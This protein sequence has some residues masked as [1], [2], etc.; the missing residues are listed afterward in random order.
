MKAWCSWY[1]GYSYLSA[2]V[3]R[4]VISL[5]MIMNFVSDDYI[6]ASVTDTRMLLVMVTVAVRT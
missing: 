4:A 5:D 1:V 6:R 3:G 2:V